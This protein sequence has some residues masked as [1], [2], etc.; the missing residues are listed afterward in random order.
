MDLSIKNNSNVMCVTSGG[1]A[2]SFYG[3][4]INERC[5]N[6]IYAH[7]MVNFDPENIM[8]YNNIL[9]LNARHS[10]YYVCITRSENLTAFAALLT[11]FSGG[12]NRNFNT[13]KPDYV[14]ILYIS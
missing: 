1:P 2:T 13:I 6:S 11:E 5:L 12:K 4:C 7:H 9:N 10:S 14:T 3:E 8:T